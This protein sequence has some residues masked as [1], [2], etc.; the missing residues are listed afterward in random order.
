MQERDTGWLQ[1]YAGSVQEAYDATLMAFRIAEH[2]MSC[3]P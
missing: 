3:F 2:E 1:V